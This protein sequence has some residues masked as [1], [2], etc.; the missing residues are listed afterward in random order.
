VR[1]ALLALGLS[2]VAVVACRTAVVQAPV[3]A[4]YV[5]VVP[6]P[7]DE[8]PPAAQAHEAALASACPADTLAERGVCVRVVASP[9][10]PAWEPAHGAGDPCSTWTGPDGLVDCDWRNG[11]PPDAG[12]PRVK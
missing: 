9:E 2:A 1:P 10:I 11:E 6:A 12:A 4:T 8:A 3:A 7:Q 5:V